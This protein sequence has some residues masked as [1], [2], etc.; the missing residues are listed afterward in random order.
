M[1]ITQSKDFQVLTPPATKD[2]IYSY[3]MSQYSSLM[4][5]INKNIDILNFCAYQL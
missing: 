3:C 4:H 2:N 5:N 1:L